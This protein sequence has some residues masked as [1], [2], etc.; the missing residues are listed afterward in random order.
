MF[1]ADCKLDLRKM[2]IVHQSLQEIMHYIFMKK[3]ENINGQ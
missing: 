1:L 3:Y 2:D